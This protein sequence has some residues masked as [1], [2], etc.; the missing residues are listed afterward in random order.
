MSA[1]TTMRVKGSVNTWIGSSVSW[2]EHYVLIDRW[3][4]GESIQV[5]TDN[6]WYDC[7]PNFTATEKYRLADKGARDLMNKEA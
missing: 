2:F 1:V 5:L 4:D 7:K 6:G 3:S